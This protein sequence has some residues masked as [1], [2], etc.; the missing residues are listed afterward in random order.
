VPIDDPTVAEF[1]ARA[2][3]SGDLFVRVA[4]VNEGTFHRVD[5]G[6]LDIGLDYEPEDL[7]ND[8]EYNHWLEEQDRMETEDG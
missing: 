4:L 1:M 8:D 5:G 6:D 3:T 2:R 7:L